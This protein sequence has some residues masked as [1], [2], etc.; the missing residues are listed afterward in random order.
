MPYRPT[1]YATV[2]PEPSRKSSSQNP[3]WPLATL[4]DCGLKLVPPPA[5]KPL[6]EMAT[7][8]EWER[9]R[10][11]AVEVL[12]SWIRRFRG[13]EN[14]VEDYVQDGIILCMRFSNPLPP[15]V[16]LAG[17]VIRHAKSAACQEFRKRSVR[18]RYPHLP[19]WAKTSCLP[20][21]VDAAPLLLAEIAALRLTRLQKKVLRLRLAGCDSD[22]VALRLGSSRQCVNLALKYGALGE[23]REQHLG[24][25]RLVRYSA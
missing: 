22:E 13:N 11:R 3:L 15:G 14:E 5:P 9:V 8:E 20:Q 21:V 4:A 16:S 18:Q 17:A 7:S 12:L 23:Y 25:G 19:M 10:A 1:S 2:A 6:E 24:N